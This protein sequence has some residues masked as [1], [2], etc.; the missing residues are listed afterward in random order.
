M[1]EKEEKVNEAARELSKLGASKG[2]QARAM[3]LTPEKRQEIA[4]RAVESRWEKAGKERLPKATHESD[5]NLK[6]G[7]LVLPCAVLEGGIRVLTSKAFLTAL[8]RPWKGSYR[9]TNLPNFLSGKNLIP[10]ISDELRD[11]LTPIGFKGLNGPTLGYKAELLP[12][13][14]E[15]YLKARDEGALTSK[16]MPIARQA[17]LLM[18]GLAR[19]GIIAL[20][21]EAT[22]YQEDRTKRALQEI[23][24]RFI[25]KELRPWVRTFETDFY[26]EIFRLNRWEFKA[27]SVK[28]PGVIGHWT[29]DIVY[30]RLAP[31]LREELH[32]LAER[33]EK[34]R[35]KHRLFQRL[36]E[37]TGHPKLREHLSAVTALMR[38]SGSWD[39][40]KRL[41]DK[42]LPRFGTTLPL[43]EDDHNYLGE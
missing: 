35:P 16:Q 37:G 15:V 3:A 31:G 1:T 29:N 38:A 4:R 34:G 24:E 6:I 26:K 2:G 11:V 14:C 12:S 36:T 28:R 19:V 33:D 43:F 21:D 32:R 41:L 10:F 42:A 17:E 7:D 20:I 27:D 9:R 30:A 18:R 39:G 5:S 22:G 40:F 25:A 8:G 23:L 13:V